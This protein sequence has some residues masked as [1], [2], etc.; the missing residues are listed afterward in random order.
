MVGIKN[1]VDAF[2]VACGGID[3]FA[4]L[5]LETH[6][7]KSRAGVD[8]RGVVLD[9]AVDRFFHRAGKDLAVRDIAVARAADCAESLDAECQVGARPLEVHLVRLGHAPDEW[10]LCFGHLRV[11]HC[12]DAEEKILERL[13]AHAGTLRHRSVGP[14]DDDPACLVDAIVEYRPQGAGVHREIVGRDVGILCGVAGTADCDV[15][16]A[17]SHAAHLDVTYRLGVHLVC[18]HEHLPDDTAMARLD[19]RGGSSLAGGAN[20]LDRK[21]VGCISDIKQDGVALLQ[22]S[23][24]TGEDF[25]KFLVSRIGHGAGQLLPQPQAG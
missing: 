15:C 16:V 14:T 24:V 6:V 12:A 11:V 3:D 18:A 9:H 4:I 20:Q 2:G 10:L 8:G 23:G 13:G 5:E 7:L 21:R 25:G 22:F 19:Q 1:L 17:F